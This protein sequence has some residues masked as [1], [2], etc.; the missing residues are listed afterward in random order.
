MPAGEEAGAISTWA[1]TTR[2]TSKTALSLRCAARP[3]ST[4]A[5]TWCA[6]ATLARRASEIGDTP[7]AWVDALPAGGAD[8]TFVTSHGCCLANLRRTGPTR[9]RAADRWRNSEARGSA[10]RARANGAAV[11][12]VGRARSLAWACWV[13]L[14]VARQTTAELLR[15]WDWGAPA[16]R[17]RATAAPHGC[18]PRWPRSSSPHAPGLRRV[19]HDAASVTGSRPQNIHRRRTRRHPLAAPTPTATA[20]DDDAEPVRGRARRSAPP[21]APSFGRGG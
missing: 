3:Q 20:Q 9:W 4:R 11:A 5:V 14:H 19:Q 7:T 17:S 8:T 15:R 10:C 1:R 18:R 21:H 13:A 12:E 2:T 6:S 16:S